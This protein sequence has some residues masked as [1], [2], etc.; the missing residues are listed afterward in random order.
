[1]K[2]R[3]HRTWESSQGLTLFEVMI[4]IAL[5]AIIITPVMRTFVN[6]MKVNQKARK[7]M[8]A[9]DVAQSIMEGYTGKTYEQVW[10]GMIASQTP[11]N[12]A[13]DNTGNGRLAFSAINEDYFNGGH[14]VKIPDTEFPS[15]ITI[16]NNGCTNTV[17]G[18]PIDKVLS[19]VAVQKL[20]AELLLKAPMMPY[21]DMTDTT[22]PYYDVTTGTPSV[23]KRI[24]F[25]YSSEKYA[26]RTSGDAST[27]VPKVSYM[28]YNRVQKDN[29]FFDVVV[30][31]LPQPRNDGK[32]FAGNAVTDTEG[33]PALD[34][35]FTYMVTV[36]V[37]EYMYE[38]KDPVTDVPY[39]Y[40]AGGGVVTWPSRFDGNY[41]EGTP[42]A[43][44]E[45][46]IQLK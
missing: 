43:S 23:D 15:T 2:N 42:L 35:Y 27:A 17:A 34:S 22:K 26:P 13:N 21:T 19:S 33:N 30:T 31:F 37:Y 45:S 25:G 39:G 46:G 6:S 38:G 29:Y 11:I 9:T 24:Y 10:D 16:D 41:F 18:V 20:K 14:A 32:D 4:A 12:Y 28:V 1:M 8:I 40:S 3:K 5:F 36:N 44:M 7:V